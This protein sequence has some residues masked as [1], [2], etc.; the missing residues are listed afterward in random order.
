MIVYVVNRA[1]IAWIRDAYGCTQAEAA[2]VAAKLETLWNDGKCK[3]RYM[4]PL[5]I[6]K[7]EVIIP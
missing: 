6:D 3:H 7:R 1:G 5:Y 2:D 4:A